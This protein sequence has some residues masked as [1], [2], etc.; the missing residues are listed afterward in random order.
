MDMNDSKFFSKFDL[1]DGFHQVALAEESRHKT[2]F[3]APSGLYQYKRLI[4][5]NSVVQ[6]FFIM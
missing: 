5:G 1:L 3:R 2:T 4:Q 6:N